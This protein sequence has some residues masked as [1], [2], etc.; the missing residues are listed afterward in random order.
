MENLET[1]DTPTDGRRSKIIYLTILVGI[2]TILLGYYIYD[3]YKLKRNGLITKG[4]CDELGSPHTGS[5]FNYKFNVNGTEYR[6]SA[7]LQTKS[8]IHLHDL[9]LIHI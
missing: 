9:S 4:Y 6:G 2:A 3:S 1:K 8:I 5:L 7:G